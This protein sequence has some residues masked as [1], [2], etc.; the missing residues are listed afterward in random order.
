MANGPLVSPVVAALAM[1]V[2][3][4]CSS[5]PSPAGERRV[6]LERVDDTAIAQLWADG[7]AELT[8]RDRALCYHLAQAAIAGRDIFLDQRFAYALEIRDV[9]EELFVHAAAL[10]PATAAELARYTKL[11]WVHGGIHH[12]LSTRKLPF[13]LSLDA[14]LVAAERARQDG[15]KLPDAARLRVLFDVMTNERTFESVTSKATDDGADP[16]R[17]SANNLY[18]GV[19]VIIGAGGVERIVEI[20]LSTDEKTA[21]DKSVGS[22][23]G[24]V[25]AMNAMKLT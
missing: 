14:F 18:V 16:V 25:E 10:E 13:H 22:V 2:L 6:L 17:D 21:F 9:L 5:S 1:A 12:N 3:V 19:P 8:P 20:S 23:K 7:F 24:L 11:F 15:A 4:S